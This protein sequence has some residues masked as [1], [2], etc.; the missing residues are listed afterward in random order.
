MQKDQLIKVLAN[1]EINI[2]VTVSV[3]KISSGAE[4]KIEAAGGQVIEKNS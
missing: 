3:D 2:A 1:G 4:A